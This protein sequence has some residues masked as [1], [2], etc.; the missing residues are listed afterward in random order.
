MH[1]ERTGSEEVLHSNACECAVIIRV[2][3][4][5]VC[6]LHAFCMWV[7]LSGVISFNNESMIQRPLCN[8]PVLL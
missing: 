5:C 7:T 8:S 6:A 2:V 1:V 3:C 4:V